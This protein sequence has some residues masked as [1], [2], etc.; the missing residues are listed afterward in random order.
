MTLTIIA[1]SALDRAERSDDGWR[2]R[3]VGTPEPGEVAPPEILEAADRASARIRAT[4]PDW[5]WQWAEGSGV[6]ALATYPGPISWWWY[7]PLS[8]MS[9]LRSALIGELYWLLL[10]ADLVGHQAVDR[11]VWVGD[12]PVFARVLGAM[13]AARGTAFEA[14]LTSTRASTGLGVAILRRL[15]FAATHVA[16][17]LVLRLFGFGRLDLE[18]PTAILFSRFPVL[19]EDGPAGARER[20]FGDWPDALAEDGQS[21][22]FAAT[23]SA[24]AGDIVAH[25]H[26]WRARGR[27]D[28]VFL[29]EALAS[30]GLLV[31]AHLDV[32]FW[33]RYARWCR[34]QPVVVF[35]DIDI[36]PLFWRELTASALS[37]ELPADRVL[38][39]TLGTLLD[40]T[41]RVRFVALPFE[42]QP[43]ERAV[44]VAAASHGKATVGLQTGLYT[45][46]QMGFTFP[47][48]QAR[49][50]V[51]EATRA[52]VPDV[53]S[54]YGELPRREFAAR[55]GEGRVFGVGPIRYARLAVPPRL[56]RAALREAQA[57]PV[58]ATVVLVTTSMLRE[59]SGHLLRAAFQAAAARPGTVLALKFHYHLPLRDETARL[60]Q[61]YPHVRVRVFDAHLD[62]LLTLAD[63][64]I[65]GGSSTGIEA[66]ARGCMPLVFRSVG[67]LQPSPVLEV[68]EA[69]FFWR[70][71]EELLQVLAATLADDA[72]AAARRAHWPEALRAQLSPL[73]SDMN[74]RLNGF[75]RGA[76]LFGEPGPLGRPVGAVAGEPSR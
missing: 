50:D 29:V 55:L 3:L 39:A 49:T 47:A 12:D 74:T 48:S 2:L 1:T 66:M 69:A 67:E 37:P 57:L 33:I 59:E 46:N 16:R 10:I 35:A 19:W 75:L 60:E 13:L 68:A 28:R 61:A 25:R 71:P 6:L 34:R 21:V 53:L 31:R 30:V 17:C 52:P 7:T 8:E 27:R 38:A 22:F 15:A 76:G 36:S 51:R 42:Y 43:V 54:A 64:M 23:C 24:S 65:C 62:D 18:Q 41:P 44:E 4:F 9:P 11:V 45:A 58:E 32:G 70:T 5:L 63:A 72:S 56:S 40:R 73:A 14:R 20:M 26:A